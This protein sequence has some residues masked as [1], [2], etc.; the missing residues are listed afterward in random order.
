MRR[1]S[2]M[3]EKKYV[4]QK[5]NDVGKEE[6]KNGI[7]EQIENRRKN[8][9]KDKK[10]RTEPREK[11]RRKNKERQKEKLKNVKKEAGK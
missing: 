3:R 9:N 2:K 11:E 5:H 10:K 4:K 1:R 6:T 7:I 8:E